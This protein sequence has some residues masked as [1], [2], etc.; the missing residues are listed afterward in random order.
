MASQR[1]LA[2]RMLHIRDDAF[3]TL[4]D[5]NLS[6]LTVAGSSP[7]FTVDAATDLTP[8]EDDRIAR[9]VEGTITVP[10]YVTKNARPEAASA[11]TTAGSRAGW[12]P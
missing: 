3:E 4:G 10:R 9:K 11:S 5:T 2:G 7:A 1:S 12:A 8:A 6:D